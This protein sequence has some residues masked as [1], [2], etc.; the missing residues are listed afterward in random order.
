[1]QSFL[2][3]CI[4]VAF[5][6]VCTQSLAAAVAPTVISSEIY[7]NTTG[8][9]FV[10][11][12]ETDQI[13]NFYYVGSTI[14]IQPTAAEIRN[15]MLSGGNPS[16]IKGTFSTYVRNSSGSLSG[17]DRVSGFSAGQTYFLYIIAENAKGEQSAVH[18]T[19]VVATDSTPPVVN[20]ASIINIT[21]TQF[22][23]RLK[24]SE[25]VVIYYIVST[26]AVEPSATQI[27]SGNDDTDT[28]AFTSGVFSVAAANTN[29]S[30]S[31]VGL[32]GSVKYYVYFIAKDP[33]GNISTVNLQSTTTAG[34][35]CTP[36]NVTAL[37]LR[38]TFTNGELTWT[39]PACFDEVLVVGS[40]S[41]AVTAVPTGDGSAYTADAKFGV[42]TLL[43]FDQYVLYR[44]TGTSV[45]T[46]GMNYGHPHVTV[47]TRTGTTWSSGTSVDEFIPF[48]DIVSTY[49]VHNTTDIPTNQVFTVTF[50]KPVFISTADVGSTI[51][52]I[53]F[54]PAQGGKDVIIYRNNIGGDGKV[55]ISG[56]VAT[57]TLDNELEIG[58]KY[59]TTI[60]PGIFVDQY[61]YDF[62]GSNPKGFLHVTTV[63]TGTAVNA[64]TAAVCTDQYTT[65]GDI[66]LTEVVDNNFQ[67]TADGTLTLALE[68]N[69]AGFNFSP[70]TTG[71]TAT[72]ASGG[73]IE[74]VIVTSLSATQALFAVKFKDVASN[75]AARDNH[76]VI[77]LSGLK[78]TRTN[79]SVPPASVVLGA[80]ST[81][82]VQGVTP[83]TTVLANITVGTLPIAPAVV[84]PDNKNTYCQ[85]TDLSSI[86]VTASGGASY[87]W[88]T[89]ASLTTLIAT[90]TSSQ[91]A[92]QLFGA[93]PVAGQEKRY[94]TNVDGC[95][96]EATEVTLS[97]LPAPVVNA[98]SVQ[99]ICPPASVTL[100]GAPTASGG[101]GDYTYAWTGADG[102]TSTMANPSTNV[103]AN[104]ADTNIIQVYTLLVTDANHCQA[105]AEVTIIVNELSQPVWITAP[106]TFT[107]PAGGAA[108]TLQG[109]P[110]GGTF[111]GPGVVQS[112]DGTYQFNPAVATVGLWPVSYTTK[113]SN[114][115]EKSLEQ[116]FTV[117]DLVTAT[118]PSLGTQVAL[119]P[120]PANAS[121]FIEVPE[122]APDAVT[123]RM[124]DSFGRETVVA[125]VQRGQRYTTVD[126]HAFAPGIYI[127]RIETSNSVVHRRIVIARN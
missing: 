7:F 122:H 76:D 25:P 53:V 96:S 86:A 107:Y 127:V 110:A 68:F 69:K 41:G 87:N 9:D 95:R 40:R 6:N 101:A 70:S 103:L 85:G 100:G 94:V 20:G 105:S 114:G 15:G 52:N 8:F 112:A 35:T 48:M 22:D 92:A 123:V 121:L 44:G 49:P 59:Y 12:A 19:S 78:V 97:I 73:D 27:V 46:L 13:G 24:S 93:S 98:G 32:T 43:R 18:R 82:K 5:V 37:T 11:S 91:T 14:D 36:E 2:R 54:H 58:T 106:A 71:V 125:E 83:G 115:C 17:S 79:A 26:R 72:A 45:K 23:L 113:L 61:G 80:T 66:V 84:W 21:S 47:F 89:D 126:T 118:E 50:T 116:N 29:T 67:G 111:S 120:N 64:P 38:Y 31:I 124:I 117:T 42:G 28:P 104:T 63:A 4:W 109:S 75:G 30:T 56:N 1:M 102:F 119:Y 99:A 57:I 10:L 108:V 55:S 51:P 62:G 90:G 77:T 60:Y 88:Y 33:T 3:I 39:N 74:S 65:L 34:A 81:L 16:P